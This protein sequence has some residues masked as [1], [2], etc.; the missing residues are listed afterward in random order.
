MINSQLQHCPF[1]S[2]TKCQNCSSSTQDDFSTHDFVIFYFSFLQLNETAFWL[3]MSV[4]C[5]PVK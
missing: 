5:A 4:K 3:V 2:D 1:Q